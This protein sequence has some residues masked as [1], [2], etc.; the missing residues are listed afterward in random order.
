MK[1]NNLN[2]INN[3]YYGNECSGYYLF[4]ANLKNQS[5]GIASRNVNDDIR[6]TSICDFLVNGIF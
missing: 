4:G 2:E 5:I 6:R 3:D 1:K